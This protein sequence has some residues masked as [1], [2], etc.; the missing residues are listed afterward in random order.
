MCMNIRKAA[1]GVVSTGGGIYN[2]GFNGNDETQFNAY[3]LQDLVDLWQEFCKENKFNTDS[4]D[5]VERI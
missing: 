5:Y 4:V 3:N 2:I 1:V